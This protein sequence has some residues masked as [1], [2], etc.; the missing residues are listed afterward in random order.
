[1]DIIKFIETYFNEIMLIIL[2]MFFTLGMLDF[3]KRK[4]KNEKTEIVICLI[5]ITLCII[6]PIIE[7]SKQIPFKIELCIL[8]CLVLY[9]IIY[10]LYSIINLIK[11]I[12]KK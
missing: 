12:M 5:G 2:S 10:F 7:H 11:I 1:M 6:I 9:A 8:L 3:S 4:N